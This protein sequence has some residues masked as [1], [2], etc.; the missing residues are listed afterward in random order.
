MDL[1]ARIKVYKPPSLNCIAKGQFEHALCLYVVESHFNLKQYIQLFC[2]SKRLIIANEAPING[3]VWTNY[4]IH[5]R[6][7][8]PRSKTHI[9]PF[10]LHFCANFFY[11]NRCQ[12]RAKKCFDKSNVTKQIPKKWEIKRISHHPQEIIVNFST[13]LTCCPHR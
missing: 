1:R 9:A 2:L 3:F 6:Q 4:K 5:L 11:H 12:H 7:R 8:Y 13:F 10:H